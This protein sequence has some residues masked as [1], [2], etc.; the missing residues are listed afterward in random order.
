MQLEDA[1]PITGGRLARS[2]TFASLGTL[3]GSTPDMLSFAE[4]EKYVPEVLRNEYLSCL[5]CSEAVFA[6]LEGESRGKGLGVIVSPE[7]RWA[8][9]R[10]H[11]WLVRNTEFYRPR[12]ANRIDPSARIHPTAVVA[13]HNVEIG[14]HVQIGA[15]V[16]VH[17]NTILDERVVI[18]ANVTLGGSGFEFKR[19]GGGILSIE[20]GGGVHL[21]REVEVLANSH[22]ARGLF[23]GDTE[24]GEQT[25]IDALVNISH[26]V[27][28]GRRCLIAANTAISGSTEVG[29]DVWIG[30]GATLADGLEIGSGS[31]ISL[32][33]VVVTN[34]AAGSRVTGNFA[35]PHDRFLLNHWHAQRGR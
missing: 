8:F 6:R 35:I 3:R 33:A 21:H 32:G 34:V 18:R 19:V 16:V 10:L 7:P 5:V 25:K 13:D 30:T 14:P 17:P 23:G 31:T 9:F 27:R 4:D 29:D 26:N 2:G 15:H 20:H 22:I 24:V 1:L 12:R 28:I 11:N